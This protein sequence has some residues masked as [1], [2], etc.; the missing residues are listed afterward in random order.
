M[1]TPVGGNSARPTVPRKSRIVDASPEPFE[2]KFGTTRVPFIWATST[3]RLSRAANAGRIW[4]GSHQPRLWSGSRS[5]FR[6]ASLDTILLGRRYSSLSRR[7]AATLISGQ[8]LV[9]P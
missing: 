6:L 4:R 3:D 5:Q 8:F 7:D 1:T 9:A 2:T